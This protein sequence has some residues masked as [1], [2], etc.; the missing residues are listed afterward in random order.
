MKNSQIREK[1]CT[2]LTIKR[3]VAAALSVNYV[4]DTVLCTLQTFRTTYHNIQDCRGREPLT[5]S[6]TYEVALHGAALGIP[7]AP[8]RAVRFLWPLWPHDK[9][10]MGQ[11]IKLC[12][13][14]PCSSVSCLGMA[15]ALLSSLSVWTAFHTRTNP[16]RVY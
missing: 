13:S 4:P 11:E 16:E 15:L 2:Y 8:P 14:P 3:V 12:K 7:A 6:A 5:S 10:R 1:R 9:K